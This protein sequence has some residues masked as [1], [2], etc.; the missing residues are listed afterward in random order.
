MS[1]VNPTPDSEL[2]AERRQRAARRVDKQNALERDA[3]RYRYL[4]EHA[5]FDRGPSL[6]WHLP[7][8]YRDERTAAERLDADIDEHLPAPTVSEVRNV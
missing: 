5:V 4:R 8:V 6:R 7:R 2:D 3:R 1:F